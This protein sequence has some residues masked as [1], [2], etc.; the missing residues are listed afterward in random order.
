MKLDVIISDGEAILR[1]A[2][3]SI[4][5]DRI[6]ARSNRWI[7]IANEYLHGSY[8]TSVIT[9]DF[10]NIATNNDPNLGNLV[11]I[12]KGLRDVEAELGQLK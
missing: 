4:D 10:N 5:P 6:T 3:K 11:S 8:P 7:K 2:S 12:L 9:K 1:D